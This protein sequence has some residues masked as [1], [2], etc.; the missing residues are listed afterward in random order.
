MNYRFDEIRAALGIQ[1][2]LKLDPSNLQRKGHVERYHA[3]LGEAEGVKLPWCDPL[4]DRTS[5]YH[6]FPILLSK[7]HDRLALVE[8]MRRDGVQTSM[9]YPAYQSFTCYAQL[10]QHV[11][12]A[13]EISGRVLTLPLFATMGSQEIDTVC[14]SLLRGL[15]SC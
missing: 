13:D 5:S 11:P 4:C 6:I 9:H 12:T 1:Q 3:L 7:D 2:L 8:S 10:G 14:D 15:Q